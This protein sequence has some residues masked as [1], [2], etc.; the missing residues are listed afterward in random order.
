MGFM[1]PMAE[2][3]NETEARVYVYLPAIEEGGDPDPPKA[4]WYGRLSASGYLD[5]TD[6]TGPFETSEEALQEV[7]NLYEVDEN[8]DPIALD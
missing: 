8:G 7:M 3:L 6:W 5:A 4:G 2:Y 1:V